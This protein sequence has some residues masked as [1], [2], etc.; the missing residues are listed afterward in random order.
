[1][2]VNST[3]KKTASAV[4]DS[5]TTIL[6]RKDEARKPAASDLAP[7]LME[8]S[9]GEPGR[10]YKLVDLPLKIGRSPDCHIV[11]ES[12]HVSREH[13]EIVAG[14]GTDIVVRDLGSANGVYVNET[15]L[16]KHDQ[17]VLKNGDKIL[18]GD[19]LCLKFCYQDVHDESFQNSLFRA[20][21]IDALTQL[22]NKKYFV[23]ILERELSFS[24]R[25]KE[26]L[27]LVMIDVDYFKKI[28]DQYGHLAGDQVLRAVGA[29]LQET[30]RT[31]NLACRYGGEEFAVV[32][33]NA[34]TEVAKGIAD[35]IRQEAANRAVPYSGKEL[36]LTVSVGVATVQGEEAKS[37]DDFVRQAD[38]KLYRAKGSGRNCVVA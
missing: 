3:G 24:R 22:Y 21:N 5:D 16:G 7:Y 6:L 26:P 35:R 31:E 34:T 27:S 14:F 13:A 25:S 17:Y 2:V 8:L 32:L 36:R 4:P 28:N 33:R 23:D 19:S 15:R 9:G 1:M 18:I 20:A 12:P 38:E 11:Q 29:L 37:V 10:M 30:V